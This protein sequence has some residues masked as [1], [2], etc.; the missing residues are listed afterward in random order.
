MDYIEPM[1][2]RF[3][4]VSNQKCSVNFIQ[5]GF[6]AVS[7]SDCV[8]P[9]QYQNDIVSIHLG[10]AVLFMHYK[11]LAAQWCDPKQYR[12]LSELFIY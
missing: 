8:D 2:S 3:N 5:C 9:E 4:A 7:S 1:Q 11:A 6:S 10:A 12:S